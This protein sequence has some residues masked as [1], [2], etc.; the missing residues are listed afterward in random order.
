M[1]V[2]ERTSAMTYGT[3]PRSCTTT[4]PT[5]YTGPLIVG[6]CSPKTLNPFPRQPCTLA[7]SLPLQLQHYHRMT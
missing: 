4:N 7:A 5:F 3:V 1:P 2:D 6:A